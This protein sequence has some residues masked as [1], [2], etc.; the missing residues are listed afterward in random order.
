MMD[1]A[2]VVFSFSALALLF[3]LVLFPFRSKRP[4]ARRIMLYS[5]LG[6]FGSFGVVIYATNKETDRRGFSSVGAMQEAD[7]AGISDPAAWAKV[8]VERRAADEAA[9]AA[10]EAARAS[11]EAARLAAAAAEEKRCR[12]ELSCWAEKFKIDASVACRPAVESLARIDF[13]WMDGFL[14]PK[15]SHYGWMNKESGSLRY[16][17]DKIQLQNGFG[18]WIRHTYVCVYDPSAKVVLDVSATPGKI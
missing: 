18:A 5:V 14:E 4:K 6:L 15:F 13:K 17:G 10:A 12:A 16:I 7:K 11:A 9:K 8:E 3:G 1:F 2:M